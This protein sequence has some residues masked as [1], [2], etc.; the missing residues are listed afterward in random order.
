MILLELRLLA[1][2]PFTGVALD[3]TRS[4]ALHLVF[5]PNEA[6]KSTTLRAIRGLLYG[7]PAMTLDAHVHRMADLRI[8][9]RLSDGNGTQLEIVRRKGS[10]NTLLDAEGKPLDDAVLHRFL[11]GVGASLFATM[12][13]LD[14][15]SLRAGG[16]ALLR[17]QGDIGETLFDAGVGGA[18]VH[19]VLEDLRRQADDL[20]LPRGR[21]QLI[22]Q[23]IALYTE[24]DKRSR[25]SGVS[26][27]AWFT[28][29]DEI[30]AARRDRAALQDSRRRLV[31]EQERLQRALRVLPL[32]GKRRQLAAERDD[33][34]TV[35][36]LAA[37]A[38]AQRLQAQRE[39]EQAAPQIAR[40]R[41]SIETLDSRRAALA[42]PS[43]LALLGE[44]TIADLHDRLGGHRAAAADLPK[45]RAEVQA[46]ENQI[47]GLLREL[48]REPELANLD[49]LRL[50]AAAA[51]RVRSLAK[52]QGALEKTL[53]HSARDLAEARLRLA[54]LA[55][56]PAGDRRVELPL[57][58]TVDR[59]AAEL[60]A[61]GRE[62]SDLR[63]RERELRQR[64]TKSASA[65]EEL[66]LAGDVPT[67]AQ[68]RAARHE[69]DDLWRALLASLDRAAQARDVARRHEEAAHLADEIAD[70]LR[71]EGERA[72]KL[73]KLLADRHEV[74]TELADLDRQR[75]LVDGQR[76][77]HAAA[78]ADLWRPL[79]VEPRSPAEMRAWLDERRR[80]REAAEELERH[81][82]VLADR[83][84]LAEEQMTV[85][86]GQW[87]AALSSIG[88]PAG[89][90]VEEAETVL[91]T[92]AALLARL[93]EANRLRARI[94][95]M[96]RD[97]ETLRSD[98][99]ALAAQH[100]PDLV[101]PSVV[102]TAEQLLRRQREAAEQLRRRS[103]IEAQ[104][105]SEK[106]ELA[107]LLE[108][109][110]RADDR[111]R[112]L[113]Q[114]AGAASLEELEQ[115]EQRWQAVLQLERDARQVEAEL[116]AA[117]DGASIA[118]LEALTEGVDPDSIRARLR[119]IGEE[120]E[121]LDDSI[122]NLDQTIV[123]YELGLADFEGR[124]AA[125]DA[126]AEAQEHAAAIR[127]GVDR[128]LRLRLS[129]LLLEREIERYRERH[130][131]PIL[132]RANELFPRLTLGH[133]RALKAGFTSADEGVLLCVREDGKE[134]AVEGLSD[135]TRDQLY[136][137]LRLASL[138]RYLRHNPAMPIVLDDILIHFDDERARAAL[139]VLG[140]LAEN[141]QVLFFTHHAR[142][143]E[144]ARE[145]VPA[146]VE[147]T[148]G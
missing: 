98:V 26:A 87:A 148:L 145:V 79:A 41:L 141:A 109:A 8:G 42:L 137:A 38:A 101:G 65:I 31:A 85:W 131:G 142:I 72:G 104:T 146:L 94:A 77:V 30:E 83:H 135:G 68:L 62:E 84:A 127:S 103:E 33:L 97:A 4:P 10:K 18:G 5:G 13:G 73:A 28:Q 12:F 48:G 121:Q 51:A 9:A 119:E 108:R 54:S 105:E 47:R 46:L 134:V 115:A 43:A 58:A 90:S 88:L 86:R 96:E 52:R 82:A 16:E 138:E 126:A 118:E 44:E 17:G 113:Q 89:A 114:T 80:A 14:H 106:D 120:S 63:V 35:V 27:S 67:E 132:Q 143:R 110:A 81:V 140:E 45:R 139:A 20:F 29:R 40:L 69:R 93:D 25:N 53:E 133:Y 21:T 11:G 99:D 144:I 70:R 61:I 34:G 1:F 15:E 107:A 78:W 92:L 2:G 74:E 49:D 6:G 125:V 59:F 55:R 32:L 22:N 136:L 39:A 116:M 3:L 19:Q 71:R 60:D 66:R 37:D 124:R 75:A 36:P 56:M 7:I 64:A 91:E 123:R 100:A 95:A 50:P 130:Q 102:E 112:S 111:L 24:A 147:H 23:E 122:S 129:A 128:Y 117:G 57:L 76:R